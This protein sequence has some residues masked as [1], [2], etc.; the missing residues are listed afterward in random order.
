MRKRSHYG[1]ALK[2]GEISFFIKTAAPAIC[3]CEQK[4]GDSHFD[5][6]KNRLHFAGEDLLTDGQRLAAN[7]FAAKQ[8]KVDEKFSIP[9]FPFAPFCTS[10]NQEFRVCPVRACSKNF[11]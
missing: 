3:Y 6:S 2:C 9:N 10:I 5:N 8:G 4:L 7:H 11:P 1:V